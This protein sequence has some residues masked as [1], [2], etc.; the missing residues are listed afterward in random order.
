MLQPGDPR[1][2]QNRKKVC[3]QKVGQLERK[4]HWLRRRIATALQALDIEVSDAENWRIEGVVTIKTFGG[5]LS[6]KAALPIM[7][8]R[9]F[10]QGLQQAST[11]RDFS[12]WSQSLCWLPK[13]DVHFRVVPQKTPLPGLGKNLI[14]LGIEKLCPLQIY[15]E[16]VDLSLRSVA[17]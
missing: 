10:M 3:W 11:L 15:N 5:A 6:K 7:T 17:S 4:V 1:E 14:S 2:V 8:E 13:K 16:F 12:A 9:I